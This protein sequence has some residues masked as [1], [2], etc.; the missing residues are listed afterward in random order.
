MRQARGP[1]AR[2]GAREE[3]D[4]AWPTTRT[5]SLEW[6]LRNTSVTCNGAQ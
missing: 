3:S 5:V 4:R 2:R 1:A 6:P